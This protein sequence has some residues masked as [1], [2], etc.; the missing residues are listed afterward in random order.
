MAQIFN[1]IIYESGTPFTY[2]GNLLM[3]FLMEWN[4]VYTVIKS[5]E[6]V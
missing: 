2:D 5:T 4:D 1:I 6:S 3:L